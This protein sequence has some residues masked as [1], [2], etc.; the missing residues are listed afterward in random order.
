ELPSRERRH[1]TAVRRFLADD[2]VDREI[3]LA[4]ADA[5]IGVAGRYL[6]D[7]AE[8]ERR[9]IALTLGE[10]VDLGADVEI[11]DVIACPELVDLR[12]AIDRAAE[13]GI[14]KEDGTDVA[15]DAR[16]G[17]ERAED[18]GAVLDAEREGSGEVADVGVA[19]DPVGAAA[20]AADRHLAVAEHL[21]GR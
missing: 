4:G 6:E 13:R 1:F 2:R 10:Q 3:E 7:A 18:L 19:L 17:E 5:L 15:V 14:R 8:C 21:G 16:H 12:I 20:I 9:R 11:A